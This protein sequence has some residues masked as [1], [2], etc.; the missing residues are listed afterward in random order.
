[1]IRSVPY[2]EEEPLAEETIGAQMLKGLITRS[3]N[4]IS[5]AQM[6]RIVRALQRMSRGER[7][8]PRRVADVLS[9][10]LGPQK[11]LEYIDKA[12]AGGLIKRQDYEVMRAALLLPLPRQEIPAPTVA[13]AAADL[14]E[15]QTRLR[16]E[17]GR[18]RRAGS[19]ALEKPFRDLDEDVKRI[20]KAWGL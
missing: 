4:D 6:N 13:R 19:Q 20:R 18:L 7:D 8:A 9:R 1:M 16:E 3:I 11:A 14:L 17:M 2:T 12:L 5:Y 15:T 10:E